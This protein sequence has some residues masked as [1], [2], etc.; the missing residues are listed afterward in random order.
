MTGFSIAAQL[1]EA[2]SKLKRDTKKAE[3]PQD[4][5]ERRSKLG[6]ALVK[7]QERQDKRALQANGQAILNRS[8]K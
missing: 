6:A 1:R 2:R 4:K 8:K 3:H 7:R 5:K